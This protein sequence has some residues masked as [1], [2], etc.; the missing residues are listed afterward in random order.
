MDKPQHWAPFCSNTEQKE[1]EKENRSKF[2][3]T[4]DQS[5]LMLEMPVT[6]EKVSGQFYRGRHPHCYLP[7]ML[8]CRNPTNCLLIGW[9]LAQMHFRRPNT[10]CKAKVNQVLQISM[11]TVIGLHYPTDTYYLPASVCMGVSISR[12]YML[13]TAD[14]ISAE[15]ELTHISTKSQ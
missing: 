12:P 2:Q 6:S 7:N 9:C 14:E 13:I 3:A 15:S 11:T 10:H 1:L 4:R 5:Q 8:G